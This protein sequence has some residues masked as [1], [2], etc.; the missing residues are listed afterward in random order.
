M[1][2]L[3]DLIAAAKCFFGFH[4]PADKPTPGPFHIICERRNKTVYWGP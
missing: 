4:E 2:K 1:K 3:Q